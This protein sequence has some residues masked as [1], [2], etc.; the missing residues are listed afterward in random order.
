MSLESAISDAD[1]DPATLDERGLRSTR[2]NN[3]VNHQPR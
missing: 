3:A 2:R 1:R